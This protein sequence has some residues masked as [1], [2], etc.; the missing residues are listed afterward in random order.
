MSPVW[1]ILISSRFILLCVANVAL[2]TKN[3]KIEC[4]KNSS[5]ISIISGHNAC[6]K[7]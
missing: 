6:E 1:I 4:R 5:I 7:G 2:K 3:A